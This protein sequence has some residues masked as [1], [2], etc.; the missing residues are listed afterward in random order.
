MKEQVLDE[1]I[2]DSV[3]SA[4]E[5]PTK[6]R[7]K[8]K[9]KIVDIRPYIVS[10]ENE[11][12]RLKIKTQLVENRT[13]RIAEILNLLFSDNIKQHHFQIHRKAQLVKSDDSVLTPLE[14]VH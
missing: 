3:L 1:K 7:V 12:K 13:V 11:G 8:G 4:E 5:L 6:R 10:I 9:D 2:L 14:M